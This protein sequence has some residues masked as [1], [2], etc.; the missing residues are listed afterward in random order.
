MRSRSTLSTSTNPVVCNLCQ[1]GSPQQQRTTI[2]FG[3]CV[4]CVQRLYPFISHT[5]K[6]KHSSRFHISC[7]QLDRF[8]GVM[9]FLSSRQYVF[10]SIGVPHRGLEGSL[11]RDEWEWIGRN[12]MLMVFFSFYD[13]SLLLV[14]AAV[15]PWL[16][17]GCCC[18]VRDIVGVGGACSLDA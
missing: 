1:T 7:H 16:V 10:C 2:E 5:M 14:V 3:T 8:V 11:P 6:I 12:A 17:W 9:S 15:E 4:D 18:H 13:G